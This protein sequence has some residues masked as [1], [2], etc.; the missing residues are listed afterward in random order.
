MRI[1]NQVIQNVRFD[2]NTYRLMRRGFNGI[3]EKILSTVSDKEFY[4]VLNKSNEIFNYI[5]LKKR[6]FGM[7]WLEDIIQKLEMCSDK[8]IKSQVLNIIKNIE[9]KSYLEVENALSKAEQLLDC[10]NTTQNKYSPLYSY[11]FPLGK[12]KQDF[13]LK[14]QFNKFKIFLKK[15]PE[16]DINITLATYWKPRQA[17]ILTKMN[18]NEFDDK[19]FDAFRKSSAIESYILNNPEEKGLGKKLYYKY[20]FPTVKKM[21]NNAHFIIKSLKS[22]EKNFGTKIFIDNQY[23]ITESNLDRVEDELIIWQTAS[24][25]KAKIPNIINFNRYSYSKFVNEDGSGCCNQKLGY[26]RI[27]KNFDDFDEVMRHEMTHLNDEKSGNFTK[28]KI[29]IPEHRKREMEKAGLTT[30]HIQYGETNED[31]YKA[32]FMEGDLSKY[33]QDFKNEMIEKGLPEYAVNLPTYAEYFCSKFR[34][35]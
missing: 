27:N 29:T 30:E 18:S 13:W 10:I 1:I 25:G 7:T 22:I 5:S 12:P 21:G 34:N 35:L 8:N 20:Y 24:K 31:E 15:E 3:H 28:E 17:Y 11:M 33:S 9:F 6:I 14:T 26:I 19:S 32:V 2:I 4:D 23:G 16:D